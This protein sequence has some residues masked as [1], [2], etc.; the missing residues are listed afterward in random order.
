[1]TEL[2]QNISD[3][4]RAIIYV[5]VS[6]D[7][8]TKGYSLKTQIEGCENYPQELGY[9][10]VATFQEDY[11]VTVLDRPTLNEMRQFIAD[12]MG[13]DAMIVYDLDRMARKSVHQMILE[14]ELLRLGVIVEYVIGRYEDSDEGRLQKQIRASIAEYEKA[15]ILERSKRGK[16]GKAKSGFVIVGNRPPYGYKSLSEPHRAWLVIDEDEAKVVKMVYD[17]FLIG[18]GDQKPLSI[19]A[20]SL[21]LT[22][23]GLPTR[24]D[25]VKHVAKKFGHG[26]WQAAMITHILKNETYTGTWHFGKT[27][28]VNDGKESTRKLKSKRGLGKQISRSKDEWISVPVP[29]IIDLITFKLAKKRLEVN[30]AHACGPKPE[31]QYLMG[32]RLK[33]NRCNYGYRGQYRRNG[34]WYYLCNGRRQVVARCDMPS[35]SGRLVDETVWDWVKNKLLNTDNLTNGLNYYQDEQDKNSTR[36]GEM[37]TTVDDQLVTTQKQLDRL[38]D[39]YINGDIPKDHYSLRKEEF[40][41]A[42]TKLK[43]ERKEI[44]TQLLPSEL[45]PELIRQLKEYFDQ[46]RS[47]LDDASFEDMR[48]LIDLLDVN[49]KLDIENE[50]KVIYIKCLISPQQRLQMLISP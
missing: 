7:E 32:K 27:K 10:V 6:T 16:R 43:E 1:M 21:K 26:V 15:K 33:C 29:A 40:E 14:E 37:L 9:S 50:E 31:H 48:R 17:L 41:E 2:T 35:F 4:K 13:I 19:R 20:I 39:L 30:K 11:A 49:G 38:I 36:F 45:A 3:P 23:L 46:V 5:R 12:D 28:M 22:E 24:G 42:I 34:N 25:K 44:S 8:Q 47:R 18:D